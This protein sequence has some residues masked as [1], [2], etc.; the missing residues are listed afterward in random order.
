MRIDAAAEMARHHLRAEADAE[1]RLL[2]A[3][4]HA[5]PVDLAV[6][7]VLVVVGALRSA[8]NRSAGMIVHRL[9]QRIAET[10]AADVERIAEL[11]QRLAD[12]AGRGMLLVQ[13]EEDRLQ[14]GDSARDLALAMS[15]TGF[16]GALQ[17]GPEPAMCA[18]RICADS[19]GDP[20]RRSN[21]RRGTKRIRMRDQL[22][23][24]AR[25]DHAL[26]S[27]Q[28]AIA[29]LGDVLRALGE[30]AGAHACR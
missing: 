30:E 1:I 18:A 22:V 21:K 23:D 29:S 10:R 14:H 17:H 5:D 16:A 3:Q 24:R 15:T 9:R 2:V 28:A 19:A 8:E 13:D 6:D 7:E 11:G 26:P 25:H 20:P 4:R 12:P 27:H